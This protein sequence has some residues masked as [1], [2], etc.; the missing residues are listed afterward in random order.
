M[1]ESFSVGDEKYMDLPSLRLDDDKTRRERLNWWKARLALLNVDTK[2]IACAQ[3][4][5]RLNA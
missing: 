1:L 4:E 3:T 5:L 2:V